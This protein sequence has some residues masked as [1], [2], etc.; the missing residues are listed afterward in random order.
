MKSLEA[1]VIETQPITQGLLRT[2]RTIGEYK[3]KQDLFAGQAPQVL[4]TLRQAAVIQSTESSN[5]LEGVIAPLDRI[6]G[7]VARKTTPRNRSEQEIAGYRDALN[8]IHASHANMPFNTGVVLQLHRDLY[9][10]LPGDAGRWKPVDNEITETRPDGTKVVRFKPI[11]AHLTP[12]A[13]AQLH[14]RFNALWQAGE[15]E[16]LLLIPTYVLDFLCIH[17]FRDGNGRMARL[18]TLLLL[19]KAGYE[20]G[21][22]IS[23]EQI[24]ERTRESYYDALYQSSQGWHEGR[25]ELLPWWEYFLGVVVLSAYQD[26]ERRV[27]LVTSARGAKREMVFEVVARLPQRFHYGDVERACPGVSRPTI[28]RALAELRN[29]GR[30]RCIK[31][32]RDAV[33]ERT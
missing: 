14:E 16:P 22:Y 19:Y 18:L 24:V 3:G 6:K 29:K 15:V 23:L 32:G 33:W 31:P 17:P 1:R 7:L 27:G 2:I 13:M 28:N 11:S 20:V 8:T 26:F 4:E 25:H 21:R 10:F 5:R 9:Q 30:I 12:D